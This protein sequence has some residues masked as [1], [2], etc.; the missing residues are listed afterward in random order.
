LVISKSYKNVNLVQGDFLGFGMTKNKATTYATNDWVLS[1]D[2]DEVVDADF[3]INLENLPLNKTLVYQI[4]RKNFYQQKYI[5]H[6]WNNDK[7]VH[8]EQD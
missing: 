5:K 3:L 1:L 4:F 6:C 2:A 8:P 7:I